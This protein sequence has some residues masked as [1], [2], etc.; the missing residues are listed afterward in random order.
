MLKAISD[1]RMDD[2]VNRELMKINAMEE[3]DFLESI[4][5]FESNYDTNLGKLEKISSKLISIVNSHKDEMDSTK[6]L[7]D[8]MIHLMEGKFNKLDPEGLNYEYNKAKMETVINAFKNRRNLEYLDYKLGIYLKTS[9]DNIRRDF[10]NCNGNNRAKFLNDLA[11]YFS[12]DILYALYERLMCAFG[13]DAKAVYLMM[14]FLAK[15]MNTEKKTSKDIW[16]K[17]LI[18]NLADI[19]NNIFDIDLCEDGEDSYIMKINKIFYPR[20]KWFLNNQKGIKV[21]NWEI[22]FGVRTPVKKKKEIIESC[23][24]IPC[25]PDDSIDNSNN[26]VIEADYESLTEESSEVSE[27]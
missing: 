2:E 9:K 24:A 27:N 23:E 3:N 4:D 22:N 16:A 12:E 8:E 20:I 7:T 26:E 18:L 11:R 19:Y 10:R 17:V 1:L 14:G 15:V 25:A 21:N 6:F 13:D 5:D